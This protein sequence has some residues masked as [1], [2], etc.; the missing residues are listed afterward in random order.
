MV[1]NEFEQGDT[2]SEVRVGLVPIAY[3]DI[4]LRSI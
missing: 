4:P 1:Y 2:L 3:T